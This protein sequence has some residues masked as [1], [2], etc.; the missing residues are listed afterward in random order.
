MLSANCNRF[1][2]GS[3]PREQP[4]CL[5]IST[6]SYSKLHM[7]LEVTRYRKAL[8]LHRAWS[9]L[10]TLKAIMIIQVKLGKV[11]GMTVSVC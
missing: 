7:C 2:F 1:S 3:Q 5:E 11:K 4:Y 8:Q 6:P 10:V 9:V